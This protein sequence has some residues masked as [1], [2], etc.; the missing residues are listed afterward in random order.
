ML[1]GVAM[2]RVPIMPR[3]Q[4]STRAAHNA[5]PSEMPPDSTSG[6]SNIA[7]TARANDMPFTHP[8]CPP[9]PALSSTR[10]SAPTCSAFSAWRTDATSANTRQPMSCSGRITASGEPTLAI[11][12]STL[13]RTR[14]ST[15]AASTSGWRRMMMFGHTGAVGP[16]MRAQSSAMRVSQASSSSDVRALTVGNDPITPPRQAADTRSGPETRSIGAAISGIFRR[17]AIEAG[18]VISGLRVERG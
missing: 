16:S 3:S 10:P 6:P 12:I 13:C 17:E 8:V 14:T 2:K 18:R 1:S 15:S 9:A 11:T 7:R 5:A 4:P